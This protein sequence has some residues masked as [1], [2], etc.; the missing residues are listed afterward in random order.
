MRGS[1]RLLFVFLVVVGASV[2]QVANAN[3]HCD[4]AGDGRQGVSC[5]FSCTEY[6]CGEDCSSGNDPICFVYANVLPFLY[7]YE[8][9]ATDPCGFGTGS[10]CGASCGEGAV[11]LCIQQIYVKRP[12]AAPVT[13]GS[14]GVTAGSIFV[15]PV[16][17][18][19]NF[20]DGYV[21]G[22]VCEEGIEVFANGGSTK[23][24]SALIGQDDS[25]KT[26]VLAAYDEGLTTGATF[27]QDMKLAIYRTGTLIACYQLHLGSPF[28]NA[29][30]P[31]P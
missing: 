13:V 24:P 31:E 5:D 19:C 11:N 10:S 12:L 14:T 1:R 16:T 3:P 7:P 9:W 15:P 28:V 18:N 27:S 30:T 21:S 20:S 26:Y 25:G 29:C 17:G 4:P 22:G 23:V 6:A 8:V 2:P